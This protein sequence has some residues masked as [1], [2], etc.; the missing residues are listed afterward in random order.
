[1]AITK[2][3]SPT[4]EYSEVS[5]DDILAE[6]DIQSQYTDPA[7]SSGSYSADAASPQTDYADY[8]DDD[9]DGVKVYKPKAQEADVKLYEPKSK[10]AGIAE[11]AR[12]YVLGRIHDDFS[13]SAPDA[14]QP[15][16][17]AQ[18]EYGDELYGQ[19]EYE[20][21]Y[22]DDYTYGDSYYSG[23]DDGYDQ[24]DESQDYY[25]DQEY[26]DEDQE[27]Y[28]G[29][30]QDFEAQGGYYEGE[31]IPQ[32]FESPEENIDPRFNLGGK[33][34]TQLSYGSKTLDI[35][36]DEDYKGHNQPNYIPVAKRPD[37]YPD[38]P[39]DGDD[40]ES[41]DE[42]NPEFKGSIFSKP[43]KHKDKKSRK[44]LKFKAPKES[45]P[46][47]DTLETEMTD[48]TP[49]P[50]DEEFTFSYNDTG[51]ESYAQSDNYAEAASHIQDDDDD[52][53]TFREY[54]LGL[55]TGVLYRMRNPGAADG[56]GSTMPDS[57]ENL[58]R[59]LNPKEATKYYGSFVR[60]LK[61]RTRIA[62]VL[63]AFMAYISL[64][65]PLPGML[66]TVKV[67]AAMC[68]ALQLGITLLS[69]DVFT[70]AFMNMLRGRFG[71]D[72]MAV[73]FCIFTAFDS[74]AVVFGAFGD[75]HLPLC[76]IS[77]LSL[78]GILISALFHAKGMRKALRV[79]AIA[80]TFYAVTG[81]AGIKGPGITLL[82]SPRSASGFLHRSEEASPDETFFNKVSPFM[83]AASFLFALIICAVQK[84]WGNFLF[85]LTA[86]L[87]PTIPFTAL[88]CFSLPFFVG[89]ARIFSS[90]AAIAGWSG[91]CD[92]GTSKNLVV[93]DRDLFPQGSV[94]IEDIRI[95][96]NIP[97]EKIISYAGTMLGASG[98][99]IASC[100]GDL[101]EKNNC[102]PKHLENFECLAGGGFKGI[103]DGE[104]VL[105]G[106]LEFM[107][108]MNVHV[109]YK[110]IDK[111]SVLLAVDGIIY[112]IF[113]LK[114]TPQ[115]QVKK[116]LVG[117]IKSN[118]HPIFAIRDFNITPEMIRESFD[119]A[120][121]GYDFPPYVERFKISDAVPGKDSKI[122]AVV[123]REG[124]APLIHMADT[125]RSMFI[126]ARVNI[127]LCILSCV[128]G[129]LT[130]V[131]K[132]LTV[133]F[134]S[135]GFLLGA[136]LLWAVPVVIVSTF[137]KF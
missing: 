24:C 72:F 126:A 14:Q 62:L 29:G 95:F 25:D 92:I 18:D 120:T 40:E 64:G 43:K 71:A 7:Y 54:L 87:A 34:K 47:D 90:G 55:L 3:T 89:S 39:D 98:L 91:L 27:Y 86:C 17:Y 33:R 114:Y 51:N 38:M 28:S 41:M 57:D 113:N 61:L 88:L 19:N 44:K 59:E 53:P 35:S 122:A 26:Y 110:L 46:D 37:D 58:G 11:G 117:L 10:I 124:L 63:L 30:P 136:A 105:C 32:D 128:I 20:D 21:E 131:V 77:S 133:G 107:R 108:L 67:Q 22:T 31:E 52:F 36:P 85:V 115:E 111:C 16:D 23:D 42:K 65:L 60:S 96:S 125:G 130:V 123:C 99:G 81:V 132:L 82:K 79:P 97:S 103:I 137:L 93:T 49:S 94:K 119:V 5:V 116:A 66:K 73:L 69:L 1:M 45:A 2:D 50:E 106:G 48:F 56:D 127:M 12:D 9:E 104:T 8:A 112:G 4:N 15:E 102:A 78:T 13:D 74:L 70:G 118:R 109:P 83:L 134:V 135:S 80:K 100:F 101:M 121:D 84:S 75:I 76:L 6:F 129:F 68:L